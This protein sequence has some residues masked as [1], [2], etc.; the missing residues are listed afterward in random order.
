MSRRIA[1]RVMLLVGSV[2]FALVLGEAFLRVSFER[3]PVPFLVYAHRDLKDTHPRTWV[4]LRKRLPFLYGRRE[5]H[6]VGWTFLPSTRSGGTNEDSEP[7]GLTTSAEGFYTPA[8]P[9]RETPQLVTLGDSFLSTYYVREPIA[10]VL[11]REL[12]LPVYNLAVGGWG[13]ENYRAAYLKFAAGRNHK[14][15]VVFTFLNDITDVLNWNTW[16]SEDP[17]RESFMTWIQRTNSGD[18]VNSDESWGDRHLVL[19]NYLKFVERG[20]YRVAPAAPSGGDQVQQPALAPGAPGPAKTHLETVATPGQAPLSFQFTAG[21]SFMETEPDAF[22]PGGGYYPYMQA[23]FESL[24]RL[25]ASIVAQGARMILVWIPAKERVYLPLLPR[26]RYLKYVTN[27]SKD[28]GGLERVVTAYAAQSGIAFLDL[29]GPFEA[30]ARAG[31]K[32]YFTEDGHLNSAGNELS[33]QLAAEFLRTLPESPPPALV[34]TTPRLI[35][36]RA[37]LQNVEALRAA[38]LA[39]RASIARRRAPGW[40]VNGRADGPY[41]YV[42]QW[43]AREIVRPMFLVARGVVHRGGLTVGVLQD[44]QWAVET[45]VP[46]GRFDL[47]IP[48]VKP[49]NYAVVIANSLS[50]LMHDND[51]EITELGWAPVDQ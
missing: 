45:S 30:H 46:A 6:D 35:Y 14:R 20:F 38:D 32:L 25:K 2:F 12:G 47:A 42:L 49:G 10:W 29:T 8:E 37:P 18:V 19:W 23:Y 28:I 50:K 40:V 22:V 41:T 48:V 3:L 33:G 9:S 4:E 11:Q 31:E 5:D 15:V 24:E 43:P 1:S 7:F 16:K 36:R 34:N 39:Y 44:D 13:P 26:D 17:A 51:A 21:Y 27:Q